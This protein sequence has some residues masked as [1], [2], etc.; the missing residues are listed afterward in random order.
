[1][2]EHDHDHNVEEMIFRQ[3]VAEIEN[4][5]VAFENRRSELEVVKQSLADMK[6]QKDREIMIPVGAGVM[7][8]GKI[9]DEKNILVNIGANVVVQKTSEEAKKLVEEQ[10][11]EINK[12]LD[13]LKKELERFM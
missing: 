5:L 2:A 8:L 4:Q 13:S 3:Q 1:M 7:V 6:H 9:V 10:L 11:E 12:I